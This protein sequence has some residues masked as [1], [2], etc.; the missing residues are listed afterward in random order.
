MSSIYL[1]G[2]IS[3]KGSQVNP[4]VL[5]LGKQDWLLA[6]VAPS[7]SV[8]LSVRLSTDGLKACTVTV[9]D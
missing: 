1:S 4:A 5:S 7:R 9:T 8:V 2:S 3:N 6:P